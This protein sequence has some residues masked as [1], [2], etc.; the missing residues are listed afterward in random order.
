MVDK[1]S[2][3]SVLP[4]GSPGSFSQP[5]YVNRHDGSVSAGVKGS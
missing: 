5:F 1:A 4:P 2:L 3:M